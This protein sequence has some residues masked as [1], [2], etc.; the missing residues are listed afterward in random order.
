MKSN[1]TDKELLNLA[2]TDPELFRIQIDRLIYGL[3]L[4]I[5]SID[6]LKK[7]LTLLDITTLNDSD[8]KESLIKIISQSLYNVDGKKNVVAGVCI[9]SNLLPVLNELNLDKRVSKVVVSGGFPTGQL[10]L[11]GKLSD[12]TYAIEN[13]ADEVDVP[14]NRGLFFE[15]RKELEVELRAMKS[16]VSQNKDAKLKVIL[17]TSELQDYKNIYDASLL[18]M[19]CGADFIKTSTGKV[20]KGADIY[21]SCVMMLAIKDFLEKNPDRVVGFKAA[22]GIRKCG[23]VLQYYALMQHFFWEDYINKNTF[24]IGCSS[25]INEIIN[26]I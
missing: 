5:D 4:D 14:I 13:G 24:R 1:F 21:S 16:I 25:L 15:N 3:L 22:G 12:I 2:F 10:S 9:Y 8:Y 23:Q 7:S 17:E 6:I 20:A 26:N 11:D 19:Q 18:A